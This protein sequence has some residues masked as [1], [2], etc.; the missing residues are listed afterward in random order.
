MVLFSSKD[1]N[2][3][4]ILVATIR[5]ITV[6]SVAIHN[7]GVQTLKWDSGDTLLSGALTYSSYLQNRNA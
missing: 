7:L 3:Y 1:P 6:A 4:I 5:R 2:L